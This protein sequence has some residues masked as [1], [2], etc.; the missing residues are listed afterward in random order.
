[1][2]VCLTDNTLVFEFPELHPDAV[3]EIAFHRTLRVPDD[4]QR[5]H[6]PP[7]LGKF[8]IRAV[9][10]LDPDCLPP[11]WRRRGGV[12]LPM[13]Q[14]EACWISFSSPTGY[15][16]A[17]KVGAGKVNALTGKPW[18]NELDFETRDYLEVPGQPWLDGFCIEEGMVRQFVAMPLGQGYTAEEQLTGRAEHG[19]IQILVHPMKP[20]IWEKRLQQ[21]RERERLEMLQRHQRELEELARQHARGRRHRRYA[22]NSHFG[23]VVCASMPAFESRM[24]AGMGLG[25]GGG[26][27]QEIHKPVEKPQVWD[28]K[29]RSR[30]FVHLADASNWTA[31]TGTVPPTKAP[32]AA[33]YARAQLPWFDY[34]DQ[35]KTARQGSSIL[36]GLQ[37]VL[38]LG[39]TRGDQP[40]PENESFEP[41]EP[42]VLRRARRRDIDAES[43]F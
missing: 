34:Y 28:T 22:A 11:D 38:A 33:D 35:S 30:C 4:G 40:L 6:L 43:A 23:E 9:D 8:P 20:A 25:L 42:V 14:A 37:S 3:M 39:Q 21:E 7:S 2:A 32:T 10:D 16:L 1:M 19:G 31:L 5:H 18:T 29:L 26:I 12:A 41:P 13:W 36:A 27:R 15:P 17:V 24:P